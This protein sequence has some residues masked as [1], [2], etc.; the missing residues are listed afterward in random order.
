M[1]YKYN[2]LCNVLKERMNRIKQGNTHST[3]SSHSRVLQEISLE[4][5]KFPEVQTCIVSILNLFM[6]YAQLIL[7]HIKLLI[8]ASIDLSDLLTKLSELAHALVDYK[9]S[10]CIASRSAQ[11]LNEEMLQRVCQKHWEE[12]ANMR[13][14]SMA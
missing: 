5:I 13:R 11:A 4:E 2:F 3:I 14:V 6:Q 8:Y 1:N 10:C 7:C 9:Q 12:I